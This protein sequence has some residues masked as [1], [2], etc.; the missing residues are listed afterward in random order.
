M[1]I[2]RLPLA[3]DNWLKA[4]VDSGQ[5]WT[6]I[7]ELIQ[8]ADIG[9]LTSENIK[10]EGLKSMYDQAR[11]LKQTQISKSGKLDTDVF[12][13]LSLWNQDLQN[14]NWMTLA[15]LNDSEDFIFAFQSS[16]QRKMCTDHGRNILMVDATHNTVSNHF[17]LDGRKI[18]LYTFIIRDLVVGR[19]LPIAWAFTSSAAEGSLARVIAWLRQHPGFAP[20]AVMSD[21]AL[22]IA[23]AVHSSHSDNPEQAP[24]HYWCL[25]HVLK[26]FKAQAKTYL[27]HRADKA[28][29]EFRM[30]VYLTVDPGPRMVKFW[31]RW[32]AVSSGFGAYIRKQ[33]ASRIEHWCIAFH[34][35]AHQGIHTNNY[36]EAWHRVLKSRYI[37]PPERKRIDEVVRILTS[38]VEPDYRW[39]HV[40]VNQG[41][42]T[43]TTNKYQTRA[44]ALG[45]SYTAEA[46]KTL[47]IRV[48]RHADHF[49]ID[50]F[51]NP[52]FMMYR[53]TLENK[54]NYNT[55]RLTS[56]SCGYFIRCGSAC[57]HMYYL[58]RQ[59]RLMVVEDSRVKLGSIHQ[60]IEVDLID[61]DVEVQPPQTSRPASSSVTVMS[62]SASAADAA[63]VISNSAQLQK[64]KRP[65]EL[66][67]YSHWKRPASQ[68]NRSVALVP[69]LSP[70][71]APHTQLANTNP[72]LDQP[73]TSLFS[74]SLLSGEDVGD[75]RIS[76]NRRAEVSARAALKQVS[77]LM[78]NKK[79]RAS[80]ASSASPLRMQQFMQVMHGILCN[81][82]ENA[83][84][85]GRTPLAKVGDVSSA[86]MMNRRD[87]DVLV[88]ELQRAGWDYV[89][90][91]NKLLDDTGTRGRLCAGAT[92]KYME[93][94]RE[95]C[96]DVLG[97]LE[98]HVPAAGGRRQQR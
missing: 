28:F 23:N 75:S 61:S 37:A 26:A 96:F 85:R 84:G 62:N 54:R 5:E 91:A 45:E 15:D 16:W 22:A 41:F 2:T 58:A 53:V 78:K 48:K 73:S 32:R 89:K 25:F 79:S 18:S 36:T 87:V 11:Y 19:G 24:A 71:Y 81:I 47:G 34:T 40:Q 64:R 88:G 74:G 33:W 13:S 86:G 1:L 7:R 67:D 30:I 29:D 21:C 80:F 82:E 31:L 76:L 12:K 92:V 27:Q 43:Q 35:T 90:R 63:T 20:Q 49:S 55:A 38:V 97:I 69:T 60:P 72:M 51:S 46:L 8:T 14:S 59:F 39:T 3:V 57:K 83:G 77:L 17:I 65:R 52:T 94:Y 4:R 70:H 68:A 9:D 93:A 42:T 10:P 44:K 50:S 56:C 95:R 6:K 66:T 98:E